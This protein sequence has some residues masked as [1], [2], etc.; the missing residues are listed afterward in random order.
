[1][2]RNH[3]LSLDV[4]RVAVNKAPTIRGPISLLIKFL[5][6]N[7]M[8][9]HFYSD[10]NNKPFVVNNAGG[11]ATLIIQFCDAVFTGIFLKSLLIFHL[12]ELKICNFSA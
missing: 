4:E 9:F 10:K 2:S 7:K 8:T 5:E 12:E 11:D 6:K 3:S 1:M